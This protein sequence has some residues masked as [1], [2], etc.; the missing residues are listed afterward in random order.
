[1]SV[2]PH[3]NRARAHEFSAVRQLADASARCL[4]VTITDEDGQVCRSFFRGREAWI[5][6]E[7][8]IL[9]PLSVPAMSI[10]LSDASGRLIHG[11]TSIQH[12]SLVPRT[13]AAGSRLRCSQSVKLDL[14]PG[15][16][17]LAIA[18]LSTDE[19][20]FE[21]YIQAQSGPKR[22]PENQSLVETPELVNRR[23]RYTEE[24][25]WQQVREHCR[26]PRAG[27]ILVGAEE[28]GRTPHAGLVDLPG[29]CSL[30]VE[31]PSYHLDRPA[32]SGPELPA[33]SPAILHVTHWKAGSQWINKILVECVPD[34]VVGP[35]L[36]RGGLYHW[37]LEPGRVYP[38]LYL[39]HEQFT[40]VRLPDSWRRFIVI[41]DLR[42]TL[43]S[44]YFGLRRA[45]RSVLDQQSVQRRSL[46]QSLDF[47]AGLLY[48]MDEWL[49]KC[50]RI[51][52][53]WLEAGERLLHYEELLERDLEILKSVLL[54]TC[55]LP[56]TEAQL[57][58]AVLASRFN[59]LAEGRRRGQENRDSHAR[60]GVAGD[61]R[62][63]FTPALKSA[64]K[65]R[66]GGLLV[67]TSYESDLYW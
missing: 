67:A 23:S 19:T 38:T 25:M 24:R 36:L 45:N 50:A 60:K 26:I 65:A 21:N 61:W 7:F 46:L 64:F 22:W 49:P 12:G 8:E 3:M 17:F 58:R 4:Y 56:V 32:L 15:E 30:R 18:L 43:I 1:M 41:R 57:S 31:A 51:Q 35:G 6:A 66:Y 63:H 44:A 28:T 48:L 39:T 2:A 11:K 33:G 53:S 16:Y 54:E 13:V 5:I 47:E 27:S 59:R 14:A 55:E 29:T 20:S 52:I 40:R 10:E 62:N 9:A 34:L 37:P 42:D